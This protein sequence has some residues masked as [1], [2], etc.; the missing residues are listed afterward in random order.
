MSLVSLCRHA[1]VPVGAKATACWPGL[2]CLIPAHREQFE[3]ASRK[4]PMKAMS[5]TAFMQV[6]E[7]SKSDQYFTTCRDWVSRNILRLP[8]PDIVRLVFAFAHNDDKEGA[9]ELARRVLIRQEDLLDQAN[10]RDLA[11]LLST[12]AN[13]GVREHE[14]GMQDIFENAFPALVNRTGQMRSYQIIA[15]CGAYK[16]VGIFSNDLAASLARRVM[17]L[18][19]DDN[20][21]DAIRALLGI[22][23]NLSVCIDREILGTLVEAAAVHELQGEVCAFRLAVLLQICTKLDLEEHP[24][25][26]EMMSAVAAEMNKWPSRPSK[27]LVDTLNHLMLSLVCRHRPSERRLALAELKEALL[28][29]VLEYLAHSGVSPSALDTYCQINLC[30]IELHIRLERPFLWCELSDKSR[31]FLAVVSQV[32]VDELFAAITML[33]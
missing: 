2:C 17:L 23:G 16:R 32:N 26:H 14:T 11:R 9:R 25:F 24:R 8:I 30:V 10:G 13:F 29:S 15:L 5:E 1:A 19:G 20:Q 12:L 3:G 27:P 6:S 22:M 18:G 33:F 28:R 31:D 7:R 21:F 4:C